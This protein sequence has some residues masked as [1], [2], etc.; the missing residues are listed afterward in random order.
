MNDVLPIGTKLDHPC[1]EC[2]EFMILRESKYGLFYGCTGFPECVAAHG[3]HKD[4][5]PLGTPADKKTKQAR[6]RAHDVFDQLWKDRHMSRNAAYEW[7]QDAMGLSEDEAHIGKFTEEQCDEL[8]LKVGEFLEEQ[9][10][11]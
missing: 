11:G 9:D 4:G 5:R 3:A 6:I 2:G 7:M 10:D 8:E 1:P